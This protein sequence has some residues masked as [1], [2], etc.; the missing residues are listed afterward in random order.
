MDTHNTEE[1]ETAPMLPAASLQWEPPAG[2]SD[3]PP[4]FVLETARHDTD[5]GFQNYTVGVNPHRGTQA[6]V[7]VIYWTRPDRDDREKNVAEDP[8][9]RYFPTRAEAEA[10]CARHAATGQWSGDV[11]P[12]FLQAPVYHEQP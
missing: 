11:P 10:A 8:R 5:R 7:E 6:V 9:H 2:G 12:V 1:A 3:M 4:G